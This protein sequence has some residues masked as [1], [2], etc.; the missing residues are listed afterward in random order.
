MSLDKYL[1]LITIDRVKAVIL[2]ITTL[3]GL[4]V[5]QAWGNY[6]KSDDIENMKGQ[7]TELAGMIVPRETSP[8]VYNKPAK[9]YKDCDCDKAIKAFEVRHKKEEH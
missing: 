5:W 4:G 3:S 2:I 6:S 9:V 8:K 1:A 7:I